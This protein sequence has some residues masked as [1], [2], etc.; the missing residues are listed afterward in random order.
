ML[1][2]YAIALG[3]DAVP[4]HHF[5]DA[6]EL[7]HHHHHDTGNNDH[8]VINSDSGDSEGHNHMFCHYSHTGDKSFMNNDSEVK[9]FAKK[10][11]SSFILV[12]CTATVFI[13]PMVHPV[14]NCT[15]HHLS[16]SSSQLLSSGLRA[17]PALA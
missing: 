3:H 8:D 15:V 7:E 17:P 9:V 16:D 12:G 11:L 4:H 2:S 6:Q 13:I 1:L 14:P 10:T 5:H